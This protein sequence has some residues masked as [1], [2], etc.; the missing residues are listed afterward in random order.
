MKSVL[1][2]CYSL[3]KNYL[4]KNES[5]KTIT[6]HLQETKVTKFF[7]K[8]KIDLD[9]DLEKGKKILSKLIK[10]GDLDNEELKLA[11]DINK[12]VINLK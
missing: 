3:P 4:I 12:I 2:K 1:F 7:K 9:V 11:K 8:H 6:M 10:S 5:Q